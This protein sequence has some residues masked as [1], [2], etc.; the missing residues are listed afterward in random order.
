MS[1]QP[2]KRPRPTKRKATS[3][4]APASEDCSKPDSDDAVVSSEGSASAE[5][6]SLESGKVVA[7]GA[8]SKPAKSSVR[9]AAAKRI[10]PTP[11]ADSSKRAKPSKRGAAERAERS[12]G[13]G[14]DKQAKAATDD[15]P[16]KRAKSVS[17]GTNRPAG[18]GKAASKGRSSTASAERSGRRAEK[19]VRQDRNVPAAKKVR[20]WPRRVLVCVIVALMVFGG[21]LL[22]NRWWRFDDAADIQG[23][24]K[25]ADAQRTVILDGSDIKVTTEVSYS[26]TLD[27]NAKTIEYNFGSLKGTGWYCFSADRQTLAI[28]DSQP[29]GFWVYWGFQEAPVFSD[30]SLE[31]GDVLLVKISDDTS[32]Q[33]QTLVNNSTQLANTLGAAI[34][35][36]QNL[37]DELDQLAEAYS[38]DVG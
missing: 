1:S 6:P 33:P 5:T 10:K 18:R 37:G 16:G 14:A 21:V 11:D 28:T 2:N 24:W 27:T 31:Q 13:A 7:D 15:A 38:Y 36:G 4:K 25:M 34:V 8:P 30:G 17:A 3:D 19:T 32:A 26:Y 22:W 23:E 29:E 20:K 35:E 9:S 12:S